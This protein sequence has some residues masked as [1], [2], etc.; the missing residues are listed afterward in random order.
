MH[1]KCDYKSLVIISI[2]GRLTIKPT[3]TNYKYI[4]HGV[5]CIK[6]ILK[7]NRIQ[8]EWAIAIKYFDCFLI[9]YSHSINKWW[10]LSRIHK[11]HFL[12]Y[13]TIH[14]LTNIVITFT[15]NNFSMHSEILWHFC[16]VQCS[17]TIVRE[18]KVKQRREG[19]RMKAKEKMAG[20]LKWYEI[21]LIRL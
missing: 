16:I 17:T 13:V 21:G 1:S 3:I 8:F 5:G 10:V 9:I 6:K 20:S 18:Q 11:R 19:E 15:N 12:E 7:S 4:S 14:R 2:W